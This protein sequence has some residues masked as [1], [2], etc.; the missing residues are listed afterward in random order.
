MSLE[1]GSPIFRVDPL[2]RFERSLKALKK[3]F[4]S[5]RQE[6]QF[7][8]A[9]M[10]LLQ[11]LVQEPRHLDSRLETIPKGIGLSDGIEFRKLRFEVPGTSGA[12]GEGRLMYLVNYEDCLIHLL[13]IYTHEEFKGRPPEKD[14]RQI[15]REALGMDE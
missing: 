3:G 7:V 15:L 11:G 2:P 12:A 9:V 1:N 14:L 4:K 10:L 6:Q 13:W 8:E 5:K